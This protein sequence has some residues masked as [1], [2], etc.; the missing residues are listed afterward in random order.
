MSEETERQIG[1][2]KSGII[3]QV[4]IT[5][6]KNKKKQLEIKFIS[7]GKLKTKKN[8]IRFR[9]KKSGSPRGDW[10]ASRTRKKAK[11]NDND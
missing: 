8:S 2:I 5:W 7:K 4:N 1:I 6:K 10:K 3:V 11:W 9:R